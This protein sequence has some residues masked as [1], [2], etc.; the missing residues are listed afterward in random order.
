MPAV[1][2]RHI[3]AISSGERTCENAN[4]CVSAQIHVAAPA[5]SVTMKNDLARR[6]P[7][8]IFVVFIATE[9]LVQISLLHLVGIL[10]AGWLFVGRRRKRGLRQSGH[11]LST[12]D[13]ASRRNA[14][15]HVANWGVRGLGRTTKGFKRQGTVLPM[16]LFAASGPSAVSPAVKRFLAAPNP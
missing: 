11:P 13:W 9:G 4:A 6:S 3:S 5:T 1:I 7:C 2:P 15:T 14:G 16:N 12:H 8:E 10:S